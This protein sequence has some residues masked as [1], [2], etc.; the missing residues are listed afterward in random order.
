[1]GLSPLRAYTSNFVWNRIRQGNE[2]PVIS[3]RRKLPPFFA[4][5]ILFLSGIVLAPP[6]AAQQANPDLYAGMR[7][8]LIGPYR[9][10]RVSAVAGIP[11]N[12]AVYFMGTP[13]GGVWETTDA[14]TVWKPIFDAEHVAPIGALAVA[15]SDPNIIYV[16]TG[17]MAN[18]AEGQ[19]LYKSSDGG[20]TW[21]HIGLADTLI[22]NS[23]V[24]DSRNADDVLVGA[25]GGEKPSEARG[26]YR[27]TD[28]GKTWQ[29]VLFKDD[30]TGVA[31]LTLDPNNPSVA[32]AALWRAV[33]APGRKP[34]PGP[35]A[36]IYK[37][38]DGGATW[39]Q[40][41][42]HG[43]PD[44][45][46]GRTGIAVAP[47]NNGSRLF[48][49]LSQGLF[50]SDDA[51]DSWR[52]ITTDPRVTGN[53]YF[54][55]VFVDPKNADVVYVMQTSLYRSTDGGQHFIALKG[56]PG[57]DD[58]HTMWIDPRNPNRI[59]LGVDQGATISVDGGKSW[60]PWYNQPIGQFYH[61]TTG[62]GFPY[63]VYAQQQDSG[64]AAVPSRSDFGEI[65]YRDW[66]S[67]GG[68]EFGYIAADPLNPDI[69]YAGG[70]G[71]SVVRYDR[72]TGQL[73]YL[74]IHGRDVRTSGNAPMEF[75]PLDPHALYFG[76][77][78]VLKS[79]DGAVNWQT[80]S[81]DLTE[82][83]GEK[84]APGGR[85]RGNVIT[86][87]SVSPVA[88]GEVWAGTGNGLIQLTRDDGAT[89]RNVS[90]PDL[91]PHDEIS[92]IEASHYDAATAYAAVDR[93]EDSHPYFYR[94]QD[95]GKTWQPIDNGLPAFGIA[96]VVRED[97]ES[98]GLLY[99]GTET[100]VFVSFDDGAGWQSLQLNLPTAS[101]RDLAVHG[102]DLAAA[103]FGRAL[104][105]LDDLTPL[106]QI[107]AARKSQEAYLYRP[108]TAMR[109][110]WDRNNETPLPP[111][112]PAGEN[113]PDGAIIDYYLKSAPTGPVTLAIYDDKRKLVRR[114]S[115][116]APPPDATLANVPSYWFAPPA[117]LPAQAG[118]N[119]FAWNM[120][121]EHPDALP[122]ERSDTGD[123]YIVYSDVNHVILGK[124]PRNY[125]LGP[126]IVPG[127]YEIAL[128]VDGKTYR[129]P[130]IVKMDPRFTVSQA[131][132]AA[133]LAL[134][135]KIA[136]GMSASA[137]AYHQV[138]A[139]QD[140]LAGRQ[141][142]LAANPSAKKAADAAEEFSKKLDALEEGSFRDPGFAGVNQELAE[143]IDL[144][145]TGDSRPTPSAYN[146]VAATCKSLDA[147]EA[148]WRRLVD[149]D[150]PALNRQLEKARVAKLPNPPA[151]ASTSCGP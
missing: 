101:V 82:R 85:R 145:E 26:V 116:V 83:A 57:G 100:G 79:T 80:I 49:I 140:A 16:G 50:R 68:Y 124:T 29:R 5:V 30:Q 126:Q 37:T 131:D 74:L 61:V 4:A 47:G 120:R 43:L 70:E 32:Y 53:G 130:L 122:S 76:A 98:R 65:R 8:R 114:F 84:E 9:A 132:L 44:A 59:I 96:R 18:E 112:V 55:R 121:Y 33:F 87:L 136:R 31:D 90:P 109:I 86:T 27:T 128:T 7:W 24:V 1:V 22:I 66:F 118:M 151:A 52:R 141:K 108:E 56:A 107:D 149:H 63:Y 3:T 72:R 42:G 78:Y 113:P 97:P 137:E 14:G 6:V 106:R 129:Q 133:Q 35:G 134:E 40:I 2:P 15:P 75:S 28:G 81:P 21:T 104:W 143:W 99:A 147:N 38:I 102:N 119:R 12:P 135:Q 94:T 77:Q 125:P 115:S 17:E 73:T 123:D 48:A 19:G 93:F 46:W 89:W 62:G 36:W 34:E 95:F 45:R 111:E 144:I 51:G 146:V 11:G 110:R 25:M 138:I 148:T 139:L 23:V 64:S 117:A 39:H 10:G 67:P 92:I 13:G 60:T 54:S 105:I 71:G 41:P 88:K 91:G 58:Y 142:S 20:K 150:L 69:N 103:T 127:T